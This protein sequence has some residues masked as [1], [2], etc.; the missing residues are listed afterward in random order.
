MAVSQLWDRAERSHVR[1]RTKLSEDKLVTSFSLTRSPTYT[2]AHTYAHACGCT[3]THT[4]SVFHAKRNWE[5]ESS[6]KLLTICPLYIKGHYSPWLRR[7]H[8]STITLLG[9]A[10]GHTKQARAHNG[11]IVNGDCCHCRPCYRIYSPPPISWPSPLAPAA[12]SHAP[13]RLYAFLCLKRSLT[14]SWAC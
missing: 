1:W 10:P 5:A 8:I 9:T 7:H 14:M 4:T 3:H 6:F 13:A 2:H 12:V 11:I